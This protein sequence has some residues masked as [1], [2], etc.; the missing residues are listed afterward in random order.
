M[1]KKGFTCSY[2]RHDPMY[3]WL[4]RPAVPTECKDQVTSFDGNE[5]LYNKPIGTQSD[6]NIK[7]GILISGLPTPPFLSASF[8]QDLLAS[9]SP[10]D[11]STD[12]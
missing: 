8:S 6:P 3:P 12:R 5:S 4:R 2:N 11:R 7:E 9:E 10:V 1:K